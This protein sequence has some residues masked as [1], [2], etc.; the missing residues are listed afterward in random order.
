MHSERTYKKAHQRHAEI[1]RNDPRSTE[2]LIRLALTSDEVAAN[3]ALRVLWYKRPEEILRIGHSLGTSADPKERELAAQIL[4]QGGIPEH[5]PAEQSLPILLP[6]LEQES[7]PIVLASIAVALGDIGDPKGIEPLMRLKDHPDENVRYGVVQ[8]LLHQRDD[9]AVEALMNLTED[10]DRDVRDW[11]TFALGRMVDIDTPAV[12][13]ALW[14]RV[15]DTHDEVRGEAL[16]G[17]ARRKDA[18]VVDALL[19]ELSRS[20]KQIT[21]QVFAA[22]VEAGKVLG[23]PRLCPTLSRLHGITSTEF[24]PTDVQNAL[25][26]CMCTIQDVL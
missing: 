6:M 22:I 2:E 1:W 20:G 3:D 7:D 26:R 19:Q 25:A 5:I 21:E 4:G 18:Q 9:R 12:R 15:D 23:D 17:L 14:A 11:A 24:E 16:L 8:G 13:S 10:Q